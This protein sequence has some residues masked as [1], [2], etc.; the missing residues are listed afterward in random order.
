[1]TEARA[2]T[3]GSGK[4]TLELY[5]DPFSERLRVDRYDVPPEEVIRLVNGFLPPWAG[6]VILKSKVSDRDAYVSLGFREEANV[7]G[8]FNGEDMIFMARYPEVARGES[9]DEEGRRI[10]EMVKRSSGPRV[11]DPTIVAP[12]VFSDADELASVFRRV[13]HIYPTPVE[14]PSYIRKTM[15]EG[16]LYFV[17]RRDGN[18][19]SVGSAEVDNRL[20]NAELTDCATITEAAGNGYMLSIMDRIDRELI[21]R[22]IRS[23]YSI[24]RAVSYPVNVVFHRLGFRFTGRLNRN[25]RIGT[26]IEDMNVW[27]K[28]D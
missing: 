6:K 27:S 22:G 17:V 3:L 1:M 24:A 7:R 5:V 23:R 19:V 18:I 26:G 9:S 14:D 8:Y 10:M 13:F 20:G 28:F 4:A 16:T 11:P 25:V 2:V 15:T 21:G 12:A